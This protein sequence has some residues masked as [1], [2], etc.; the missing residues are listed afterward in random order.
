MTF[1]LGTTILKS[2]LNVINYVIGRARCIDLP[3]FMPE[4][5]DHDWTIEDRNEEISVCSEVGVSDSDS[6]ECENEIVEP[7][8]GRF[9]LV[10]TDRVSSEGENGSVI[11]S[12]SYIAQSGFEDRLRLVLTDCVTSRKSRSARDDH[13]TVLR[14]GNKFLVS[15]GKE[16]I[17]KR[18]GRIVGINDCTE[19]KRC[20]WCVE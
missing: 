12:V 15:R 13:R 10:E 20:E 17:L 14:N 6:E 16:V 9:R 5:G 3:R 8:L 18:S 1:T 11:S 19:V 4:N 2:L 7:K